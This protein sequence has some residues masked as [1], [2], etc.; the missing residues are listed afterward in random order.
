MI[1]QLYYIYI[2]MYSICVYVC[3][4]VCIYICVN[5]TLVIYYETLMVHTAHN[6]GF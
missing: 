3:M 5:T 4:Y 1:I 2:H 6:Y